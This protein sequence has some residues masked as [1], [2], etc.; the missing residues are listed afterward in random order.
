[1]AQR[2][3]KFGSYLYDVVRGK[4]DRR[5]KAN[6]IRKSI[7]SE[8]TFDRDLINRNEIRIALDHLIERV[9]KSC[10]KYGIKGKT[11]NLKYR[12][13]DF[14]TFTRSKTLGGFFNDASIISELIDDMLDD[15]G[16][17]HIPIRLLGVGLS[18]LNTER[19]DNQ[20]EFDFSTSE[21]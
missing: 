4:D 5:V 16:D 21:K 18:S 3:G 19:K 17:H 12:F 8:T 10:V 20:L 1:M 9:V 11:V 7:S 6:R 13:T 14:S 2:F 15:I